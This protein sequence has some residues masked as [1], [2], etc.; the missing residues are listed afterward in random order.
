MCDTLKSRHLRSREK[1]P[2]EHPPL[3]SYSCV[4]LELGSNMC[5]RMFRRHKHPSGKNNLR[6][7]TD[8][9][10]RVKTKHKECSDCVSLSSRHVKPG[11][12]KRRQNIRR[13]GHAAVSA[14]NC[15]QRWSGE[16]SG[17][18]NILLTQNNLPNGP[19]R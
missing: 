14:V 8:V 4:G 19:K 17:G 9:S 16:C 12:K 1:T 7:A 10:V 15:R 18:I 2:A 11:E 13:S 6:N 3:G 5:R